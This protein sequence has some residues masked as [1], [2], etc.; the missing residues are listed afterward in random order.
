MD[1][2]RLQL[3]HDCAKILFDLWR[4]FQCLF[5]GGVA[6]TAAF[7]AFFGIPLSLAETPTVRPGGRLDRGGEEDSG[8]LVRQRHAR[9]DV[10]DG[11]P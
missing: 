7:Y 6:S 5:R 10:V 1:A 4:R 3:P 11:V 2:L 9:E 8:L